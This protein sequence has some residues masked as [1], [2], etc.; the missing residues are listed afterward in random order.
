MVAATE[1]LKWGLP[2][3][4]LGKGQGPR[5]IALLP[6]SPGSSFLSCGPSP[7]YVGNQPFPSPSLPPPYPPTPGP[8]LGQE[9]L[10]PPSLQLVPC[11]TTPGP[12]P[13]L[14][15]K[16]NQ[17]DP[18]GAAAAALKTVNSIVRGC[19]ASR[20]YRSSPGPSFWFHPHLIPE[21]ESV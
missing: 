15:R 4:H 18:A 2:G 1:K 21:P 11:I 16:S 12:S 19:L 7:G 13:Y 3:S 6:S 20:F 9:T 14:Q 10:T 17:V 5:A 8:L